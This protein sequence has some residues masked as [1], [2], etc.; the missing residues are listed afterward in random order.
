VFTDRRTGQRVSGPSPTPAFSSLPNDI[1]PTRTEGINLRG[2]FRLWVE[3]Y[4]DKILPSAGAEKTMAGAFNSA[5]LRM[6][7]TITNLRLHRSPFPGNMPTRDR[8]LLH[9]KREDSET[10]DHPSCTCRMGSTRWPCSTPTRCG[11]AR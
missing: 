4:A 8:M 7:H 5:S 3:R 9:G 2:V 6:P 1:A 10:A 11:C